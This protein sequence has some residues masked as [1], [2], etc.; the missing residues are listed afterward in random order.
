MIIC[1]LYVDFFN[2]FHVA[3]INL[4]NLIKGT[5][6]FITSAP[7]VPVKSSSHHNTLP[8]RPCNEKT[9]DWT[10]QL[11]VSLQ[12]QPSL[13]LRAGFGSTHLQLPHTA[14]NKVSNVNLMTD[15]W[16]GLTLD[17]AEQLVIV[18]SEQIHR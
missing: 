14:L 13:V 18:A 2:S 10:T 1:R 6:F 12:S 8:Q 4:I 7:F 17:G 11:P 16:L 5:L 9:P 15:Q 3:V